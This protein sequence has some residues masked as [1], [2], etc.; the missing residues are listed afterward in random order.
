VGRWAKLNERQLEL[1]RTIAAGQDDLK[2]VWSE[3]ALSAQALQS[4]GL[5]KLTRSAGARQAEVTDAGR[6]YLE[7]GHH[8]DRPSR[9]QARSRP[10]AAGPELPE[11][12]D[13][14]RDPAVVGVGHALSTAMDEAVT[15]L[16]DHLGAG[17]GILRIAEP[18]RE[19]RAR[20]RRVIHAA[21]AGGRVPVGYHLRY[22]GRDRGDL[23]IELVK[24]DHSQ[25]RYRQRVTDS[26]RVVV[27]VEHFDEID[28]LVRQ[29]VESRPEGM[30]V[31]TVKRAEQL[32]NALVGTAKQRGHLIRLDGEPVPV[33]TIDV[34][35]CAFGLTLFE[36]H[37]AVE[38]IQLPSEADAP[39][40]Y[41]LAARQARDGVRADR[42]TRDRVRRS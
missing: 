39:K 34:E 32:V 33:L 5:V 35:G 29:F 9:D 38:R 37:E 28:P 16:F 27:P 40:L 23:V 8:P 30:S 14:E 13:A 1:L 2:E 11:R 25:A 21:K 19:S 12:S 24:G 18:D 17:G 6:F 36:E 10:T 26:S 22:R 4:R 31:D 3:V 20:W 41:K 15:D 7:H 42:T